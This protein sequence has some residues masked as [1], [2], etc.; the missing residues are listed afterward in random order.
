[1][2]LHLILATLF[3]NALL[4]AKVSE[5]DELKF[6][7]SPPWLIQKYNSMYVRKAYK[8]LTKVLL[9]RTDPCMILGNPGIGKSYF[10]IY[11]L[12]RFLERSQTVLYHYSLGSIMYLFKPEGEVMYFTITLPPN[13]L[14][15]GTLYLYDAA[16]RSQPTVIPQGARLIVFSSPSAVNIQDFRKEHL[17]ELNMPI[18]ALTELYAVNDLGLCHD[19]DRSQIKERFD[20]FGGIPRRIFSSQEEFE[21]RKNDLQAKIQ[22]CASALTVQLLKSDT[23]EYS[24]D[25]FHRCVIENSEYGKYEFK[26][27]SKYVEDELCQATLLHCRTQLIL[28]LRQS[29]GLSEVVSTRDILFEHYAHDLIPKGGGFK[30]RNLSTKKEE[31]EKFQHLSV[32]WF[33]DLET[34][35][36]FSD[37]YLRPTTSKFE[38]ADAIYLGKQKAIFQMTVSKSHPIKVK[39]MEN[40][41][42]FLKNKCGLTDGEHVRFYFVVPSDVYKVFKD[43]QNYTESGKKVEPRE[44]TAN[45]VHQY[46]LLIDFTNM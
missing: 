19:V 43:E 13:T 35:S 31:T 10:S 20:V 18:W 17:K 9:E 1:M 16:T 4:A 2:Q 22:A 14:T 26:I 7:E 24:H 32:E 27:A 29:A 36:S 30:V 38:S 39:G 21:L 11:L 8:D 41:M 3:R 40:I 45:F 25:V 12:F 28:F 46:T 15:T 6:S 23:G 42:K 37:V 5:K 34:V 33:M 44:L